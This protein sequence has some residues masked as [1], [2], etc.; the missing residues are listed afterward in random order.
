MSRISTLQTAS[1][2]LFTPRPQVTCLTWQVS[3]RTHLG[4]A[5]SLKA[6]PSSEAAY[7]RTSWISFLDLP[8]PPSRSSLCIPWS[9]RGRL[10]L[11]QIENS[12]LQLLWGLLCP[13]S[14]FSELLTL[15]TV[16]LLSATSALTC[17]F[18]YG[19]PISRRP[20]LHLSTFPPHQLS[21]VW[22]GPERSPSR[23]YQHSS[24]VTPSS[25]C[26]FLLLFFPSWNTHLSCQ[27]SW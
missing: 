2:S 15:R 5:T 21:S 23:H 20:G 1:V 17:L 11:W 24:N 18:S 8:E 9:R 27:L 3:Q 25:C 14:S 13:C 22:S 12:C 10:T 16:S 7:L 26:F 19:C 6:C 4:T